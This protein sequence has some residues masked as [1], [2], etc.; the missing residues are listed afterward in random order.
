M[1]SIRMR[2]SLEGRHVSG[3]ERITSINELN[4]IVYELLTR[5]SD[6]D[7]IVLKVERVKEVEQI[8][9]LNISEYKFKTVEESRVFVT[10]LLEKEGI[11]GNI[12]KKLMS[13]IDSG[14]NLKGGNMRGAMIVDV[15]TGERLE[16]DKARGIR[17]VRV[18][19][20]NR[21]K[22]T[23]RLLSRGFTERTVDALA[24]ASKNIYC[25]VLAEVCWSDDPKY[26]SGYVATKNIGYVR[27]TPLKRYGDP[28][29]GRIYF[30]NKKDVNR[31]IEC[32]EKRACLVKFR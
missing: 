24:I 13:E 30:V 10:H 18:D 2:A 29:G 11:K 15:K 3:A 7:E 4:E 31:I 22:V 23:E 9:P 20:E 21:K 5:P 32:L 14:A 26:V 17:T 8:E 28:F 16:G 27:I 6:Y 12:V 19:W 1:F 25:G